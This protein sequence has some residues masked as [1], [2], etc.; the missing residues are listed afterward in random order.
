MTNLGNTCYLASVLQCLAQTESFATELQEL[1]ISQLGG[2]GQAL[3]RLLGNLRQDSQASVEDILGEL[4]E[5]YTWYQGKSQQDA[6]ELLRT[7]LA[8]LICEA[9]LCWSCRQVS[10]RHVPARK[11]HAALAGPAGGGGRGRGSCG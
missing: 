4:A 2:I 7:L 9:I 8:A 3:Q 6:H 5:R 1:K 11:C 10:L